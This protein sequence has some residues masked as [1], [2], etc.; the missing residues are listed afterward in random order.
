[1]LHFGCCLN[2]NL[3]GV[4]WCLNCPTC[5]IGGQ[6]KKKE[7]E[8]EQQSRHEDNKFSWLLEL[9]L[10][11]CGIWYRWKIGVEK[12]KISSVG[13]I[14]SRLCGWRMVL[15]A[16]QGSKTE[17]LFPTSNRQLEVEGGGG[18]GS[19]LNV[20]VQLFCKKSLILV[21]KT[22]LISVCYFLVHR[23]LFHSGFSIIFLVSLFNVLLYVLRWFI[24]L[25][26]I[27]LVRLY[28]IWQVKIGFNCFG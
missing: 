6:K 23:I 9:Q 8:L 20:P 7:N 12:R 15:N 4:C 27:F 26:N 18:W 17:S 5:L 3:H 10:E 21:G 25:W 1:M 19:S 24:W 28:D 13:A 14:L 16:K 2:F 22:Q 11:C